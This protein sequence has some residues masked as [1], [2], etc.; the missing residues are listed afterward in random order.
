MCLE[1]GN[2]FQNSML[3]RIGQDF[4]YMGLKEKKYEESKKACS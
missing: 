4:K 1:I 2:I 3:Y